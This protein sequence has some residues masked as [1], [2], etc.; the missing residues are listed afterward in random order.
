M[1]RRLFTF[2]VLAVAELGAMSMAFAAT[3][4]QAYPERPIRL[5][6]GFPPGGGSD[7]VART[8]APKLH[9]A[10][11]QSW[12][13]DNRP[14]AGGNI[15]TEIVTQAN[16]DGYTVLM[17]FST[18]LTANPML[19]KV[20]YVVSRD[21]QPVINLAVGRDVL[22]LHPSVKVK[23]LQEFIDLAKAK[24]GVINYASAGVG[25]A[26]HLSAEL[27]KAKTG[28][29]IVAV[30]YRGG[31]PSVVA[32]LA[33]EVQV[34][35][36]SL[37]SVL[38]F[39]KAGKLAALAVG[40]AKRAPAAPDIPTITEAGFPGF[41]VTSWYGLLVP[42]RPPPRIVKTLYETAQKALQLA[43]GREQYARQG[44]EIAAQGPEEFAAQIRAET[45]VWTKVIRDTGIR[46]E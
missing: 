4:P 27:F 39:I 26:P 36:A 45:A 7:A 28:I 44:L 42:A 5:V 41:E 6:L 24:P 32:L 34:S 8:I 25:S 40:G 18:T 46:V 21:L 14:G 13:I 33:G 10:L 12:V 35:F 15:A 23:S 17:G 43:E 2:L 19:Y 1:T 16:P 11:G 38:P 37:P 22:V 30:H 9:E 29:N 3:T 31:G 20:P